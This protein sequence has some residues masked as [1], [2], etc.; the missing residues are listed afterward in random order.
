MRLISCDIENFGC[1]SNFHMDFSEGCNT[2]CEKNGF[3]KSTLAAFIK[4][5]FYGFDNQNKRDELLNERL[6]YNP[7]QGGVY[8]GKITFSVEEKS[9]ILSRA[10]GT[11]EVD[12]SWDLREVATNLSIDKW[13][14]NIGEELFKLDSQ[15]FLRT[16]FISQNDCDYSMTDG[17]SAKLGNLAENT[18]DINNFEKVD[19]KLKDIL[20]AMSPKR[21]T[22]SLYKVKNRI[23]ELEA[24]L[25]KLPNLEKSIQDNEKLLMDAQSREVELDI[26]IRAN[27]EKAIRLNGELGAAKERNNIYKLSETEEAELHRLENDFEYGMPEKDEIQKWEDY[28][29]SKSKLTDKQNN[30][31]LMEEN[32]AL[33]K[34][35]ATSDKLSIVWAAL[36]GV[37]GLTAIILFFIK[38][39]IGIVVAVLALLFFAVS[40]ISRK[41]SSMPIEEPQELVELRK[42]VET[43]ANRLAQMDEIT[44]NKSMLTGIQGFI[45]AYSPHKNYSDFSDAL[46]E[47]SRNLTRF[48]EL[49][50]KR[51]EFHKHLSASLDSQCAEELLAVNEEINKLQQM[52]RQVSDNINQYNVNIRELK[53]SYDEIAV[54]RDELEALREQYEAGLNKCRLITVTKELLGEAKVSFGQKYMEPIKQGFDKY[55][56]MLTENSDDD[57][58]IDANGTIL[59]EEKGMPRDRKFMSN[60]YKDL[61]GIC[62]RMSLVDAMYQEEKPFIILDDPFVNLDENKTEGG[63]KLLEEIGKEYQVIY[64]TCHSSRGGM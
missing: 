58:F 43:E 18:D 25:R 5:M 20:N 41:R 14:R 54:Y 16:V 35:H 21:S 39:E 45:N 13:G 15:S 51:A 42:E 3:G 34:T 6:R 63:L 49:N 33:I 36:S 23:G 64:F 37:F 57:Y 55:Y 38:I 26:T 2:I 48:E 40:F 22:G 8:G 9:Y 10:F 47:I 62:M 52:S 28:L 4:V 31:K 1:L 44:Y 7:W 53:D 56:G 17:I 60:G 27:Q 19:K 46:K 30:L 61:I 11:K 24:E 50:A 32:F 12:D 29:H 59:M